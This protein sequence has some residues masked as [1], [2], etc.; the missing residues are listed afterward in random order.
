MFRELRGFLVFSDIAVAHCKLRTELELLPVIEDRDAVELS[1]HNLIRIV[2]RLHTH[3][4]PFTFGGPGILEFH[5]DVIA[6]LIIGHGA[7]SNE[8]SVPHPIGNCLGSQ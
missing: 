3:P 4:H 6:G 5:F 2:A 1:K 7:H 8:I